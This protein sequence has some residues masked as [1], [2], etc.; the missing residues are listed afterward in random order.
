MTCLYSC[1]TI[2]SARGV[3][4]WPRIAMGFVIL[5]LVTDDAKAPSGT[6]RRSA[7]LRKKRAEKKAAF[8]TKALK[9]VEAETAA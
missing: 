5:E 8:A 9:K 3:S 2:V 7:G 6:I 4:V 1:R